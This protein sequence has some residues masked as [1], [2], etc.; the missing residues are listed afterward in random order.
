MHGTFAFLQ[1]RGNVLGDDDGVIHQQADTD[2][3]T[4]QGDH[5]DGH[6]GQG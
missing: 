6:A 4:D 2:Q 5:V 3:Q 1:A